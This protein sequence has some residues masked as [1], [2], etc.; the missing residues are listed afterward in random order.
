MVVRPGFGPAAWLPPGADPTIS[1]ITG[2]E[3]KLGGRVEAPPHR[4]VTKVW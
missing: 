2:A 1:Q 4:E 3:Q